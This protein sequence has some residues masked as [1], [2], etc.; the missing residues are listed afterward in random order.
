MRAEPAEESKF[1]WLARFGFLIRGLLYVVI[2]LLVIGTG[3]T[4]DLTGA[5][6]YVG[7]GFGRWLL[8][9]MV[10]GMSGY[11]AWQLFDAFFG[12]ESGRDHPRAWG[13]RIAAGTS[14]AIYSYLAWK[15]VEISRQ[16]LMPFRLTKSERRDRCETNAGTADASHTS[17]QR[18]PLTN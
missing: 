14:G 10:T 16:L 15:A 5:M 11:G 8:I 17:S 7:D 1:Q 12:T 3:R 9:L 6:G 18:S 2:A 4:E 13:R